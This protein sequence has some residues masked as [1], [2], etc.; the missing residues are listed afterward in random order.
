MFALPKWITDIKKLFGTAD[1]KV[2]GRVGGAWEFLSSFVPS[3]HKTSHATGGSDALTPADIGAVADDDARLSDARTPLSHYQDATSINLYTGNFDNNLSA[4]D[5]T[6]QKALE[7]LDELVAG[8]GGHTIEA[9]GTPV[10]QRSNLDFGPLFEVTDDAAND[11]TKVNV[12]ATSIDPT[13]LTNLVKEITVGTATNQITFDNLDGNTDEGYILECD[14]LNPLSSNEPIHLFV[15]NLTTVAN[16]KDQYLHADSSTVSAVRVLTPDITTLYGLDAVANVRSDIA[17]INSRLNIQSTDTRYK[18]SDG[19]NY[20]TTR[21]ITYPSALIT[22]ITR[23]DIKVSSGLNALGIGS[24]IRLYKKK[25]NPALVLTNR[26]L[27]NLV[28]EIRVSADCSSVTFSNLDS[29][30]DGDYI[31]EGSVVG[32]TIAGGCAIGI[33]GDTTLTNYNRE[34][35]QITGPSHNIGNQNGVCADI[36]HTSASG[37]VS[38]RIIVSLVNGKAMIR[39]EYIVSSSSDVTEIN[40]AHIQH[41][42]T[43]TKLTSLYLYCAGAYI[44]TGSVFRLYKTNSGALRPGPSFSAHNNGTAITA[45]FHT[46]WRVLPLSSEEWDTHGC[47]STSAYKFQPTIAGKYLVEGSVE[48][49]SVAANVATSCSIYKNGASYK[50]G[51]TISLG[52]VGHPRSSISIIVDLN[53]S[54][55]YIQLY[56]R[57]YGASVVQASGASGAT[58]FQAQ[59]IG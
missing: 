41:K 57:V 1:G 28:E 29:N 59:K 32:V 25:L 26:Y 10:E 54:T 15:N 55:D 27:S 46:A 36:F 6:V 12:L 3:A 13:Y 2:L 7:S 39:G 24:R 4:A 58:Y 9:D 53:G 40:T 5:D 42:S 44:G 56:G 43:V 19:T 21:C 47:Y 17:L 16:Y 33:N 20:I 38:F 30:L 48:F 34:F 11:K 51:Q 8:G 50:A 45:D 14:I 31:L 22:N 49:I 35:S 18:P 37:R 23:L 52:V